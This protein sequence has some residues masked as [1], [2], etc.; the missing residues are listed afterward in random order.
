MAVVGDE[1]HA[2]FGHALRHRLDESAGSGRYLHVGTG[3]F[4]AGQRIVE[5]SGSDGRR[6]VQS[7]SVKEG[8]NLFISNAVKVA[9]GPLETLESRKFKEKEVKRNRSSKEEQR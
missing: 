7:E 3:I 6:R 8:E 1:R 5:V 2:S 4:F 9:R